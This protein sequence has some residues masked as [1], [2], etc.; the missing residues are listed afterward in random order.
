MSDQQQSLADLQ[1]IKQMMERSSRFISLSGFSGIAAGICALIGAWFANRKI[2]CWTKGDCTL[3]GL[4]DQGGVQLLNDLMWIATLTFVA[5]FI[6][7]TLFTYL[8]SKKNG[9]P[10]WGSATSRLFWNTLIPIAIGGIFIIRM[11]QL[12]QFELVAPACLI[13]YGLALVNG[14]KYTLGEIRYLGYG[15]LALG[16][17]S[18]WFTGYGL[19][20][21]G[22]GFGILH[23]IYGFLMWYKHERN[24]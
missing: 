10:L 9:L 13:F 8:R 21:W 2:S 17:M 15:Q 4:I 5:A 22:M 7:A 11:M 6:S 20:F 19:Y 24:N 1:H 12:G 18:L 16:I 14:S 23:I 3:D